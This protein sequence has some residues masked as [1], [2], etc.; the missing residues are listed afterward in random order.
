MAGKRAIRFTHPRDVQKFLGRLINEVRRGETD[1]GSASKQGYLANMMLDAFKM[2]GYGVD[3]PQ[4]TAQGVR[5]AL[6]EMEGRTRG[7]SE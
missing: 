5:N 1:P 2:S 7:G 3:R 4:D 6:A